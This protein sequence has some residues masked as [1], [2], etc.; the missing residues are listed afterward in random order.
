[1]KTLIGKKVWVIQ[2]DDEDDAVLGICEGFEHNFVKLRQELE[3]EPS[4]YIN[5][6]NV[7]E[8]ELYRPDGEGE[9]RFLRAVPAEE[10]PS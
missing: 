10:N 8:I 7:K 4:L 9:L 3:K 1:L 2:Y 5:L 6:A